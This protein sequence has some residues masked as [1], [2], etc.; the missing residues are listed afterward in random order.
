MLLCTSPASNADP[1]QMSLFVSSKRAILRL[2]HLPSKTS[3]QRKE[4]RLAPQGI[5]NP[6]KT[7]PRASQELPAPK[8]PEEAQIPLFFYSKSTRF[9]I[10]RE[11]KTQRRV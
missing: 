6:Q 9:V 5:A 4:P 11:F 10:A 7:A 1:H 8:K 2:H 3:T